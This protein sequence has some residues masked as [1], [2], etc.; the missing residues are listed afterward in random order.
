[1]SC[2]L[3]RKPIEM[4]EVHSPL[5]PEQTPQDEEEIEYQLS[6]NR[7]HTPPN[8]TRFCELLTNKGKRLVRTTT[9]KD[10]VSWYYDP[11]PT[12]CV[13]TGVVLSELE[14]V[15]QSLLIPVVLNM[16]KKFDCHLSGLFF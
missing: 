12:N 4:L 3:L 1:M 11:L 13:S 16:A 7:R 5:S 15:I 6:V 9:T 10:N 14:P 2:S 8:T